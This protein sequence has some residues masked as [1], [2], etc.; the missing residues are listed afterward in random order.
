MAIF[1]A[2]FTVAQSPDCK[3]ITLTDTSNYADNESSITISSFST[4]TRQFIIK[5]SNGLVVETID[6]LIAEFE[7]VYEITVD[8]WLSVELKLITNTAVT[9]TKTNSVLSTCFLELCYSELVAK[10]DCDCSCSNSSSC[11]DCGGNDKLRL[12]EHIKA[13]EIFAEY[14]NPVLAQ[15]QLDAGTLICEASQNN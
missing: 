8:A 5:D 15:K 7:G 4:G 13:A 2:S 10:T 11:N 12:L 14:S 9:Y 3:T 6:L 1:S